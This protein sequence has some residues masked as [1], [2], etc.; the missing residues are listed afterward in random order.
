[1]KGVR[2]LQGIVD[3]SVSEIKAVRDFALE[4]GAYI[5][6]KKPKLPEVPF[7]SAELAELKE[8]IGAINSAVERVKSTGKGVAVRTDPSIRVSNFVM[9]TL[10]PIKQSGF[11]AEMALVYLVSQVEAFVKD[12][13]IEIL[14]NNPIMLRSGSTITY[15]E[16]SS[17][18]S[19]KS[20]QRGLAEKE[21]TSLTYKGI[22][23]ISVFFEK[24]LNID[25]CTFPNWGDLCENFYR[26][27]LVVHNGAVVDYIYKTK[28]KGTTRVGRVSTDML[29]VG[30][31]SSTIL[32]FVEYVHLHVLKK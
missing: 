31:A 7:S 1:M 6:N 5:S 23:D 18:G 15:Q 30:D 21:V 17:Y 13:L 24:R 32:A 8:L 3:A 9:Q 11:L 29:Y 27:N 2:R 4:T 22:D 12:Y 10:T 25:L 26:R 19:I 16:V 14:A 28:V 20:L